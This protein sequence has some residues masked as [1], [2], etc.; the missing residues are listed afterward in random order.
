MAWP[1]SSLPPGTEGI[2]RSLSL[3][4]SGSISSRELTRACLDRIGRIDGGI[5]AFLSVDGERALERAAAIDEARGR[6]EDPGPLAG[7]PVA[8]KDIIATKGVA[9][10]CGSRILAPYVPVEDATAVERLRG[11]GAVI[12]G[13]TNL[14]EFAMG[15]ST[16]H[17]AA[18]PTRNPWDAERVPGGSSG[19]SA[20]AVAA[21]MVPG[22]L[23]TDTGGSV[24]QPAALCGIVGLKPTYGRVSRRGLV[25]FASSLDQVGPMARS[26]EDAAL[27]LEV[28]AGSDP[29]DMTCSAREVPRF[30]A[31]VERGVAG[32]KVGIAR[33]YAG[34][35]AGSGM[36][37][38]LERCADCLKAA[39]A[40][41]VEVSLPHT[42]YAVA[43]YYVIATAEASSNLAR[44]DGVR[45]GIRVDPDGGGEGGL[46]GMYRRTRSAGFGDEVKRRI[47]LGTFVL[48]AGYFDAYYGKAQRVRSLIRRDFDSAFAACD[49][50]LTPTTPGPAFRL[51]E[52]LQ[53]PLEMYLTDIFT[54]TANLSGLP[55][56]S[57]PFALSDEG[58][59]LGCQLI[60]RFFDEESLFAAGRVI[61]RG[62]D[63][64]LAEGPAL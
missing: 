47:I 39:G 63:P 48:S 45:Y 37:A 32:L 43:T 40:E 26:V 22:A 61:E 18:G 42:R 46:P 19:G 12:L 4:R 6:G 21:R 59:P 35:G 10:T 29:R 57:V 50:L 62:A 64:R 58:L 55:A 9:T 5:H 34:E 14:D 3:L 20:A 7:I 53:D 28:I 52:K 27:L 15:S 49:L 38:A 30:T 31:A 36:A 11:A 25:A 13:K 23:G 44:Y 17:S 51:G 1:G 41:V 2:T 24:R 60:G 8:V 33:E 54:V 56:L 16:E